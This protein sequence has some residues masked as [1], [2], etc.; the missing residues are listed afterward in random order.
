MANFIAYVAEKS[1]DDYSQEDR[2][3]REAGGELR[4][5]RCTTEE[6]ICEQC[7]DA[8]ALLLRQTPVGEQAF[9]ALRNLRVV[10]RYGV[11]YDNVDTSAATRAGIIVTFV[12]DYCVG[13]V[14]DHAIALLMSVI[15]RTPLRDRIVRQG[16]WDITSR[17]PVHRTEGRIFG[18]VGYG[19]TAREVRRRLGGFPF[20][21]AAFDPYVNDEV[22]KRENT[23]RLDFE[24]LITVSHYVSI[25][26]PL[27]SETDRLFD[28]AIFR[29]MRRSAVLVNTSRGGIVDLRGLYTALRE[30]YIGGAGLDVFE[31]EPFDLSN[32]LRRMDSVVLS[33]HASWYSEESQAELQRRTAEEAVALFTGGIPENPVNPEAL[34]GK[35]IEMER[36]RRPVIEEPVLRK[37][38][39]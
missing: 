37:L 10:S 17:K 7:A 27:N 34:S 11:G 33:D 1:Y 35:I 30:G 4:F 29:R 18:L 9:G 16:G 12:P 14:A 8:H 22:F 13:E 26:A 25:H 36:E 19:K 2:I 23:I 21:F 5:A 38:S 15:R 32:P 31:K 24:K 3:V 28:L 6:D 39:N 20:R